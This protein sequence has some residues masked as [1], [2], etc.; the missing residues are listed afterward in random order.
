MAR[1]PLIHCN[2]HHRPT[3]FA[4]LTHQHLACLA[5][6]ERAAEVV[7]CDYAFSIDGLAVQGGLFVQLLGSCEREVFDT[8]GKWIHDEWPGE[9]GAYG[10]S[11]AQAVA[12]DFWNT[13]YRPAQPTPT[14][15]SSS[16]FSP[17]SPS[18]KA[19][20]PVVT[21]PVTLV[22]RRARDGKVVGTV[23]LVAEDMAGRDAELGPW[24]AAL[25]VDQR[26][27]GSGAG[28]LL[29]DAAAALARR[30]AA[31]AAGGG[32]MTRLHLWFPTSKPHLKAFY[33]A[34]GW[35]TTEPKARYDSSS[36]GGEVTIM[37]LR[38]LI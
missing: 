3:P 22:A 14:P 31:N 36:F 8:I 38:D 7:K 17:S 30:M 21:L 10:K 2:H 4:S 28:K 27:R 9:T 5:I 15:D 26:A 34:N 16:S 13:T 6:G 25:Y 29:V 37:R 19:S 32:A 35:V 12:D 23:S 1:S 33:E 20:L 11:G 24:L 18:H